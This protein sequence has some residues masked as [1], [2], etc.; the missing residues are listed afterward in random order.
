M[1]YFWYLIYMKNLDKILEKIYNTSG[2]QY[3]TDNFDSEPFKFSVRIRRADRDDDLQDYIIEVYS[4]PDM[5]ESLTYKSGKGNGMDG[6]DISVLRYRFR[7]FIKY[8]D[9]SFG[10][11]GRTVGLRFMNRK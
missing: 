11:F 5:P 8:A 7:E 3:I 1:T 10:G 6:I 2:N 4:T 9:S